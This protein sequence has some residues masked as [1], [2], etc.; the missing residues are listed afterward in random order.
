VTSTLSV[1][2]ADQPARLDQY[3]HVHTA[4]WW[5]VAAGGPPLPA[6]YLA[7]H[8][9]Q[10]W[11]PFD[12]RRDWRLSR[13]TT[14][15]TA[16]LVDRGGAQPDAATGDEQRAQLWPTG[17]WQAPFGDYSAAGR[18]PSGRVG[19]WA[20]PSAAFLA[21]LPADPG[22]L[23]ARLRRETG[24]NPDHPALSLRVL[25]GL[26]R[27]YLLPA[28]GRRAVWIALQEL[29][30]PASPVSDTTADQRP[31]A[32]LT[33]VDGGRESA[34][35]LNPSNGQL[36]GERCVLLRSDDLGL[37]PGTVTEL[38]TA[39]VAVVDRLGQ[40]PAGTDE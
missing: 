3:L 21:T 15:R 40:F 27:S 28:A 4:A 30:R 32:A 31:A 34:V 14:G 24:A 11:I 13:Q 37:P 12:R 1:E 16:A 5:M 25:T 17:T 23:L 2:F 8:I 18:T 33:W 38:T 35:L 29:A 9:L 7:E 19:S 36:M 20:N 10:Q 22:E 39:R 26:L 6:P